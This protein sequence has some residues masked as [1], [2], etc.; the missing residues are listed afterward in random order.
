M[1]RSKGSSGTTVHLLYIVVT[2][3][4]VQP[5]PS[6]AAVLR[7]AHAQDE[8]LVCLCPSHAVILRTIHAHEKNILKHFDMLSVIV[9]L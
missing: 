7:T 9:Y 3:V 4:H 6:H 8:K 1:I 5:G 2:E